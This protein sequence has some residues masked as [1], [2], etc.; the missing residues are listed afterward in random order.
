MSIR[1][2][3]RILHKSVRLSFYT[4]I[5]FVYANNIENLFKSVRLSFCTIITVVYTNYI[6]NLYL[7]IRLLL[8]SDYKPLSVR[9]CRRKRYYAIKQ[10]ARHHILPYY[11]KRQQIILQMSASRLQMSASKC[12]W[13]ICLRAFAYVSR[14]ISI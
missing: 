7:S 10:C 3:L 1:I 5:T 9:K 12:L 13:A 8:L 11:C 14:F 6:E 2:I 4:I